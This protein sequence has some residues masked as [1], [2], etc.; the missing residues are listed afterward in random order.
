MSIKENWKLFQVKLK[1][2]ADEYHRDVDEITVM[3]VSKTRSVE[4]IREAAVCGLGIFGENRVEEASEKF[5]HLDPSKHPLYLIGHLQSNKVNRI[6]SRYSGVHSVDSVKIA[7]RL[8]RH[9]ENLQEPLDILLQVNTSGEIAKSGFM[10]Y[11][12]FRDSVAEIAELPFIRLRGLMTMAPFTDDEKIVR[13]CFS[14]CREW[15]GV[16]NPFVEG[17]IILSMGMSSDYRWAVAE[18]ST[19]LRVGSALFGDRK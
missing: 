17:D 9:R 18:G 6:D 7:R 15:S 1:D 14:G 10:D 3:A 8:S 4:E 16:L 13:N 12:I 19:M 5:A 11:E 2:A